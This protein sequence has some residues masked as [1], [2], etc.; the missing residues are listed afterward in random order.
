MQIFDFLKEIEACWSISKVSSTDLKDFKIYR[1]K[2]Y[3]DGESIDI[4]LDI[5]HNV[6]FNFSEE[7]TEYSDK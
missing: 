4:I 2:A 5:K 1:I 3:L 7:L 6:G